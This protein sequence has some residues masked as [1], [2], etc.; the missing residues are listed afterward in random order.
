MQRDDVFLASTLRSELEN[1]RKMLLTVFQKRGN[2][3]PEDQRC[4]I[5]FF[6]LLTVHKTTCALWQELK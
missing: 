5:L 2:L 4:L 1:D 6:L 3:Q